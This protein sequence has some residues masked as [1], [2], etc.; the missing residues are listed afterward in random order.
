MAG[1]IEEVYGQAMLEA[2]RERGKTEI[3]K[4]EAEILEQVLEQSGE[5]GR[6]LGH[7]AVGTEEKMDLL[8]QVFSGKISREWL[9]LF[10]VVLEKG[11]QDRLPGI[12]G[13]FRQ[14]AE[15]QAGI[16]RVLVESAGKL[17]VRQ[18]N[19]VRNRILETMPWEK[20]E[21]EFRVVPELV[22]GLR[23]LAGDLM[24][25]GSV[26]GRLEKIRR[27]LEKGG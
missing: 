1:Q 17:D 15:R 19:R 11:R 21:I 7:P 20:A 27:E 22:G 4:T 12:I 25:D 3:L 26:R 8:V 9:G 24:L 13:E 23:I 16:Q 18:K 2:A 10:F 6:F 5:L 14:K